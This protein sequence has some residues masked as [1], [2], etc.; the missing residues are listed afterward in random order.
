MPALP[1]RLPSRS[2]GAGVRK[3]PKKETA[4]RRARIRRREL[5]GFERRQRLLAGVRDDHQRR[6]RR[7]E[8]GQGVFRAGDEMMFF[9]V[10]VFG[11]A[12][13]EGKSA[14][15]RRTRGKLRGS[16]AFASCP[17]SRGPDL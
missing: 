1:G 13:I 12:M 6:F 4:S 9:A 17:V 7:M 10:A 16:H 11:R 2:T 8:R 3:P 15:R 5:W 14:D